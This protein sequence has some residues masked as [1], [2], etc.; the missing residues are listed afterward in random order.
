M[1]IGSAMM[2]IEICNN[3]LPASRRTCK[4]NVIIQSWS[5]D[6]RA[7]ILSVRGHL[8]S[9][10]TFPQ[11]NHMQ[12][13]TTGRGFSLHYATVT[14]YSTVGQGSSVCRK[15]LVHMQPSCL[16][17]MLLSFPRPC[18]ALIPLGPWHQ[19]FPLPAMLSLWSLLSPLDLSSQR[20]SCVP[21]FCSEPILFTPSRCPVW[22]LLSALHAR[23]DVLIWLLP[24]SSS[25]SLVFMLR[26]ITAPTLRAAPVIDNC[27]VN[28]YR[29]QGCVT[30]M[31][32]REKEI[33][34]F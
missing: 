9:S 12:G 16:V 30:S 3:P 22:F 23:I 18:Q 10:A 20:A 29:C 27:Y 33:I 28:K 25:Q 26:M 4:A 6:L 21:A 19:P 13:S 2:E 11:L 1:G 15:T 8:S 17:W 7:R 5:K 14:A 31:R 24:G 34:F 32:V